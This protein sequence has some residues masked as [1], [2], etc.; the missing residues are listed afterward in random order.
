MALLDTRRLRTGRLVRTFAPDPL[1]AALRFAWVTL[2][3]WGEIG[4]FLYALSG[5][6]WPTPAFAMAARDTTRILLIS[7]AQ[8]PAPPLDR[9][10]LP[11]TVFFL[12]DMLT[13]GRAIESDEE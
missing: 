5:C 1:V 12:G 3:I 4:V 9:Q 8:V 6:R 13:H 7:D 2:I 11:S 10:T